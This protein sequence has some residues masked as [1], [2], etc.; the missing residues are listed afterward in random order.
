M[1][2]KEFYTEFAED[3]ESTEKKTQENETNEGWRMTQGKGWSG[4]AGYVLAGGASS[5]FGEDKAL[6]KMGGVAMLECMIELLFKITEDVIIVGPSKRR[7][8]EFGIEIVADRWP[9]EGPLG[10][11]ITALELTARSPARCNWNLIIS[12]DMPFLTE[13]WL[14]FL[15]QRAETSVADVVLPRSTS[16]PEPLCACWRTSAVETLRPAFE[17]GVRKV[18]ESVKLLNAEMLDE[19]DWKRFDS[20]GRLFWNMN[21]QS[22]YDEAR[23]VLEAERK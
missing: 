22:D 2:N 13:E 21:T 15:V 16:G 10:G 14:R 8:E 6:V 9:G 17:R 12:C 20:A 11:I 19:K 3:A 5:R 7:Y 18:M 4:V 1:K 23:R